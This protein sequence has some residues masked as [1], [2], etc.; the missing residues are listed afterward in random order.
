MLLLPFSV[1][2]NGHLTGTSVQ[3]RVRKAVGLCRRLSIKS[4]W[5]QR[6]RGASRE[7]LNSRTFASLQMRELRDLVLTQICSE[8][9]KKRLHFV[10]R[11]PATTIPARHRKKSNSLDHRSREA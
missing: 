11:V 3:S 8:N 4:K 2:W 9:W 10:E 5:G 7:H 6:T 1:L